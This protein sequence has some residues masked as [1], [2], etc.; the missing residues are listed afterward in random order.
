MYSNKDMKLHQIEEEHTLKLQRAGTLKRGSFF[1]DTKD[2][3]W[4]R[5]IEI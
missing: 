1:K 5:E 3:H 4:I 2:I